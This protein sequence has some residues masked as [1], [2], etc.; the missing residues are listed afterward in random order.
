MITGLEVRPE[1]RHM[2]LATRLMEQFIERE[3]WKG[4][5]R[6]VLTCLE[7][8]VPF[9]ESMGYRKIGLSKSTLGGAAW[10]EMDMNL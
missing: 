10:Y 1:Y 5:K 9:Y 7:K 8:L 3:R 4:R 6:I 2:G